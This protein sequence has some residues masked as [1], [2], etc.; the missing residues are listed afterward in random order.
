MNMRE[1]VFDRVFGDLHQERVDA[2]VREVQLQAARSQ[3]RDEEGYRRLSDTARDLSPLTHSRMQE[4]AVYLWVYNPIAA[5]IMETLV[6]WI[7]GEGVRFQA[8]HERTQEYLDGFWDHPINRWDLKLEER[9]REFFVFGEQFWPVFGNKFNGLMTLGVMDPSRVKEVITDPDN[10][11]MPI[12]IVTKQRMGEDERR[13]RTVLRGEAEEILSPSALRERAGMKDGELVVAMGNKLS[14]MSRG[15]SE[16]FRLAD[17]LD[18]YEQLLFSLL[19]QE[20]HRANFLWDVTLEGASDEKIEERLKTVRAPKPFSIRMHNEKEK[21]ELVGPAFGSAANNTEIARLFRNHVLGGQAMPE[22][23]Y[24]GGGDVNRATASEM[25][26]P[27]EKAFTAKQK[28]IKYLLVDVLQIQIERG[29]QH[30]VLPDDDEAR[31]VDVD[32][33]ELSSRDTSRISASLQQTASAL[34]LA[35]DQGWIDDE[36]SVRVLASLIQQTGVEA[37]PDEM[38][39][40]GQEQKATR[41]TDEASRAFDRKMKLVGT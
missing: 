21:W 1:W 3:S 28:R 37:D 14:T 40:R 20:R 16:L 38:L 34:S 15:I 32:F 35:A 24:G 30:G 23:W 4:I 29:I 31:A 8:P 10:A 27:A 17:W 19:S 7:V 13:L 22:H 5:R 39:E 41:L 2:A 12:G 26:G 33:P 25:S 18:G 9:V 36:T 11:S 6:E